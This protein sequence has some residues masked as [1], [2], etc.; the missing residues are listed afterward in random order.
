MDTERDKEKVAKKLYF[1]GGDLAER[2]KQEVRFY[3]Y[4]G[5]WTRELFLHFVVWQKIRRCQH[6]QIG[7]TPNL[8]YT[9]LLD[10]AFFM[11]SS[12]RL[13]YRSFY[14]CCCVSLSFGSLGIVP[15]NLGRMSQEYDHHSYHIRYWGARALERLWMIMIAVS[16]LLS[17]NNCG[18]WRRA[19]SRHPSHQVGENYYPKNIFG[20]FWTRTH[21][22]SESHDNG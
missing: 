8:E 13:P 7:T 14:H 1:W 5:R 18:T 20:C 9:F 12:K 19:C 11:A 3:L 6:F 22:A 21:C 16:V 15:C 4:L 17:T 10:V 2:D